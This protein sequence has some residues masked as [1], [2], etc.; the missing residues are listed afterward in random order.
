[1][2][3]LLY[4]AISQPR[5]RAFSALCSTTNCDHRLVSGAA[6]NP[7]LEWPSR[8]GPAP[9]GAASLRYGSAFASRIRAKARLPVAAPTGYSMASGNVIKSARPARSGRLIHPFRQESIKWLN[10]SSGG[11]PRLLSRK[12]MKP[13]VGHPCVLS[14]G[15]RSG[16]G[17]HN[18]RMGGRTAPWRGS[19]YPGW[20]CSGDD[21]SVSTR[22]GRARFLR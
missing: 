10:R 21:R 3:P 19:R 7:Y 6:R 13:E 22:H 5:A 1:L 14:A 8:P 15:G 4:S 12:G 16:V 17:R 11:S 20:R 9:A 2:A 18:Q